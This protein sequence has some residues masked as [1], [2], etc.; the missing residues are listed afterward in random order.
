MAHV[1][2]RACYEDPG[3]GHGRP[4]RI[5]ERFTDEEM[6]E[7]ERINAAS[8]DTVPPDP[9]FDDPAVRRELLRRDR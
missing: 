6:A 2:T 9:R 3:G 1:H 7:A 5:C 4:F 8:A